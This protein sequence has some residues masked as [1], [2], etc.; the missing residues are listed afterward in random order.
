MALSKKGSFDASPSHLLPAP[1]LC[2]AGRAHDDPAGRGADR[3]GHRDRTCLGHVRWRGARCDRHRHQPG[4]EHRLHRR[5]QRCRQL[6]H[7]E[8]PDRAVRGDRG[9]DGIQRRAVE[10]GPVRGADGARRLPDG[11]RQR[12]GTGRRRGDE[13]GAADR[14]RG[15][16]QDRGTAS[17]SSACRRRG[18]I[19][20]RRRCTWPV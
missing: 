10:G 12:R 6:H 11:G 15:R 14:K 4:D 19:C 7:H 3:P 5:H 8:R 17:R 16:R 20:R 13:R 2:R 9:S 18:G 1:E